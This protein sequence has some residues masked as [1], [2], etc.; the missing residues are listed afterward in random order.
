MV[1]KTIWDNKK[2][3]IEIPDIKCTS[4]EQGFFKSSKENTLQNQTSN[5]KKL[6]DIIGEVDKIEYQFTSLLICNN[7]LCEETLIITGQN[8]LWQNGYE[9]TFDSETGEPLDIPDNIEKYENNFKIETVSLPLQII[10]LPVEIDEELKEII[11]K[12]FKLFWIDTSSCAN[13][14]RT[15]IEFLLTQKFKIPKTQIRKDKVKSTQSKPV[16]F[17]SRLTLGERIGLMKGLNSK[18]NKYKHLADNLKAIKWIGND[19]SHN[20]E[21]ID[22]NTLFDIYKIL[23]TILEEVYS[24]EKQEVKIITK[25]INKK[26]SKRSK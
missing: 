15:A 2:K 19:G 13:K 5:S 25:A 24:T 26:Y 9:S 23:K 20:T 3:L 10:T 1:K 4:C 6:F 22:K 8:N 16:F 12:S 21:N 18:F 7:T 14:I 17:R 11:D